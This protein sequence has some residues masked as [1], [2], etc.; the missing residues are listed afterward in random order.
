MRYKDLN[1]EMVDKEFIEHPQGCIVLECSNELVDITNNL[2]KKSGNTDLVGSKWH[3]EVYYDFYLDYN[4]EE[5]T[6]TLQA[7]CNYGKRDNEEYYTLPM[8]KEEEKHITFLLIGYLVDQ[9]C[10]Y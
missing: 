7:K 5:K 10:E 2:R 1:F 8:T 6:V 4:L 3:N 9:L